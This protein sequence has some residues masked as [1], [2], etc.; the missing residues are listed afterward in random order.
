M[1]TTI[2]IADPV[3]ADVRRLQEKEGRSIGALV[4]ELVAEGLAARK[5]R[6]APRPEL[7]WTARDLQ[8]KVDLRDKDALWAVLDRESVEP[9]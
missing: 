2:D 6:S 5:R 9:R 4:S 3:L 7:R 8:P 1:R